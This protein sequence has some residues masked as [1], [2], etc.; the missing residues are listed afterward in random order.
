[1]LSHRKT[2]PSRLEP[3]Q[4]RAV[5]RALVEAQDAGVSVPKSRTEVARRFGLTSAQVEA[6]EE[7]G[8]KGDWPPL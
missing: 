2:A 6:I 7:E 1:M 4:R 3:E 5:F 8:R